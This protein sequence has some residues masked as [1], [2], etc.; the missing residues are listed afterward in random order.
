MVLGFTYMLFAVISPLTSA[1]DYIFA[2]FR[3]R[4]D[5][6]NWIEGRIMGT[7][8]DEQYTVLRAEDVAYV[9]EAWAE[10]SALCNGYMTPGFNTVSNL[11]LKRATFTPP[12]YST[13]L[14]NYFDAALELQGGVYEIE[15]GAYL[16][17]RIAKLNDNWCVITNIY[18]LGN[19]TNKLINPI[20][21]SNI[22]RN[23]ESL[24][25]ARR[26]ERQCIRA[27]RS[28]A[29]IK[30]YMTE[31]RRYTS[32]EDEAG[33]IS[34]VDVSPSPVDNTT[35]ETFASE[36]TCEKYV[37]KFA[38]LAWLSPTEPTMSPVEF[39]IRSTEYT[40]T[41]RATRVE[42]N[43]NIDT[44]VITNGGITRIANIDLYTK[45]S[46]TYQR[47]AW[48]LGANGYEYPPDNTNASLRFVSR[49]SAELVATGGTAYAY[50]DI[51]G[52]DLLTRC[53]EL[54][55]FPEPLALDLGDLPDPA[56][57]Q[58]GGSYGTSSS[59]ETR[60]ANIT[61][62]GYLVAILFCRFKTEPPL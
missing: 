59:A 48:R 50:F 20:I 1:D 26:M 36:Y 57:Y 52:K 17:D 51:D 14:G 39:D 60:Y 7:L 40:H 31:N 16:Q 46:V 49:T 47:N 3:S 13:R 28:T 37:H 21:V 30:Q 9:Y 19:D 61:I 33:N 25:R 8:P 22:V 4:N 53:L 54:K 10:R 42:V 15:A 18:Y 62:D 12:R 56:L 24:Y 6:T 2:P 11:V 34:W 32:S 5:A 44:E 35:A 43:L 45:L 55:G 23:L 29:G 38:T 58:S 27:N 41:G